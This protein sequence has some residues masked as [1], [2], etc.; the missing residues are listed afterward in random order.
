MK[1]LLC[2][3]LTSLILIDIMPLFGAF[4]VAADD[5]YSYGCEVG[6]FEVSYIEDDGSFSKISCHDDLSS[7]KKAMK[8]NPDYVVRYSKSYS[9]SK[10][11]AMNSGLAYTYPGRRNSSTMNLYQDPDQKDSSK[12]KTTYVANHYEMTY[13]DTCGEDVYDIAI[14]GKGYIR[15]VLNGFEGFTDLE[16]TDLVPTRDDVRRG[17]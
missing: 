6:Q 7:A 14:S 15:V 8:A 9:P 13:I 4:H 10:I 12:Y 11:V 17:H 1:K 3:L 16:Y 2:V 5:H